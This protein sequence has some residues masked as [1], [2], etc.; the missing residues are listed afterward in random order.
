MTYTS[1]MTCE[2]IISIPGILAK[3]AIPK[4]DAADTIL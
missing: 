4:M 1:D 2:I 3:C